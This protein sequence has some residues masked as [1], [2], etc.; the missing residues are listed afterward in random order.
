MRLPPIPRT[1]ST[2]LT[3][4]RWPS[5]PLWRA[6]LPRRHEFRSSQMVA[7]AQNSSSWP[8]VEVVDRYSSSLPFHTN[9]STTSPK[10]ILRG[11]RSI[12]SDLLLADVLDL[13]RS[14]DQEFSDLKLENLQFV[15]WLRSTELSIVTAQLV[16]RQTPQLSPSIQ[17]WLC[18]QSKWAATLKGLEDKGYSPEDVSHWAWILIPNEPDKRVDRFLSRS[19][20][21]PL[22]VLFY[23]LN[24]TPHFSN[25]ES[26][27]AL[28]EYCTTWCLSSKETAD[29]AA[30]ASG[31]KLGVTPELFGKVL[32]KL[33]Y[34]ASRLQPHALPDIADLA[35]SYVQ[36]IPL[37]KLHEGK[38]YKMQCQVFNAAL[39]AVS[40]PAKK[41]PYDSMPYNWKALTTLLSLSSSLERPLVIE[42][43]SYRAIRQVLLA[44]PKTDSERDTATTLSASWPPYRILRD[45]MEEKANMEDYLSRTVKAGIMMQEAGYGKEDIDLTMDILGGMAPD[46]SPTIQ[47]RTNFSRHNRSDQAA[48]AALIRTTRNG[49]EAWAIFKNPPEPGMKPTFEVY[50]QLIT[51]LAAKP[52][53]PDHNNLPGDGR[54][55]FTYDDMNLSEFEKARVKPPSIHRL[56][57]E[58]FEAGIVIRGP[59]L[60]WLIR[61]A[62][63]IGH[64]LDYIDHSSIDGGLKS[65]IRR[66]MESYAV[67]PSSL[68][69]RPPRDILH[70]CID[71]LCRL[72]PNRTA[73]TP[74]RHA[75]RSLYRI[76]YAFKLAQ[77][78]WITPNKSGRAPWESIL[79]ALA[80]P[81]IM[82]SN[83][84]PADNDVQ[85]LNMAT[86]VLERAE[87]HCGLNLA[88]FGSF[89]QVIQKTVYFR[90]S[91]SLNSSSTGSETKDLMSLYGTQSTT[92]MV[93]DSPVFRNEA[94]GAQSWRRLLSPVFQCNI[95]TKPQTVYTLLREASNRLKSAWRVLSTT[96]PAHGPKVNL[97]VKASDINTYMR[98]L[99]F[100][101]DYEEMMLLLLW[102]VREWSPKMGMDLSLT[103][104][105]RLA[106]A[107]RTFR[108]YAEPMLRE[109]A[110]ALLR[111]E[112]LK[113]SRKES[114]CPVYWPELEEVEE[115]IRDDEWGNH[116]NLHEI[117]KLV[118]MSGEH[119]NSNGS[120]GADDVQ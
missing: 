71:L 16:L 75:Y 89:A 95:S 20:H 6:Y 22:F 49:Q 78:G 42:Q 58:M 18:D 82:L 120:R 64:A 107:V 112:I 12:Y 98:T 100:T 110:V 73:N 39:Q 80:R 15:A 60:A 5:T 104:A 37:R 55:V 113:Y 88:M 109:E 91:T 34:H 31:S 106:R 33:S 13:Y 87:A 43:E 111:E 72:Q 35:V 67:L 1:H 62:P 85:V 68:L 76:Q 24:N 2:V 102:V 101:G 93:P 84:K 116:Q 59:S 36:G 21:K 50:W 97:L 17:N 115:H 40:I 96:G 114:K 74:A 51:K 108:A 79:I 54:E 52:A 41:A 90:L 94:T 92:L 30:E 53:N 25:P 103:D 46:G 61:Q 4:G 27:S 99:A 44:L 11:Q 57:E 77:M 69:T 26:L 9:R 7:V 19:Q 56:I 3:K 70:A 8:T 118:K 47:T 48:W 63:T 14:P 10:P 45:G 105:K 117:L 66:C 28:L 119:Q 65:N 86:E 23:L 29:G 81:N 32:Q 38:A 83:S